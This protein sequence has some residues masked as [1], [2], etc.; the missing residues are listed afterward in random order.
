ML[1]KSSRLTAIAAL[2]IMLATPALANDSVR[3]LLKQMDVAKVAP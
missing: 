1:A 3:T 2:S